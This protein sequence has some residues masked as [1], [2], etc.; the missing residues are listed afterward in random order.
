MK[1]LITGGSG[2]IGCNTAQR[3][4]Q[5]GDSVTVLDDL[6]RPGSKLNLEWLR[7]Q[8]Q[9]EFIQG[10]VRDT[11]FINETIKQRQPDVC[12]HLAAQVAVTTSVQEPRHDF[13][14]NAFEFYIKLWL[15]HNNLYVL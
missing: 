9:F 1:I 14:I 10:D 11:A 3:F 7:G 13:E 4:L 12:I 15:S 8:G 5:L 6:S 2:F